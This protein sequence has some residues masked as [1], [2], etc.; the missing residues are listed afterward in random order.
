MFF[1]ACE[2][3]E[4]PPDLFALYPIYA[5]EKRND[6]ELAKRLNFVMKLKKW[7]SYLLPLREKIYHSPINGRI[8][9]N[10]Q[11]GRRVLD[12]RVSNYSYGSLQRILQQGLEAAGFTPAAQGVLLL[13]LGGGSV[14]ETL[15]QRFGYRGVI[16][17][18]EID[19]LMIQIAKDEFQIMRFAPLEIICEDAAHYA[20]REKR[21]FDWIIVD[22]F[23]GNRIPAVFTQPDFLQSVTRLLTEGGTIIFNTMSDTFSESQLAELTSHLQNQ[24]LLTRILHRTENTNNL[25]IGNKKR[26]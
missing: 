2:F 4:K 22:I 17:C 25:L 3:R 15:R 7:L 21:R 20:V 1:T 16:T 18:V 5:S 24:G 10:W 26:T 11:Q 13:G 6:L 14:A 19:P 8:E 9:I 12:T 23:I